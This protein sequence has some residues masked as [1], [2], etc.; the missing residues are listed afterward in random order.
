M[1]DK[2]KMSWY[3]RAKDF[4]ERNVVNSKIRYLQELRNTLN[5]I[6]DLVFQ[7]GSLAKQDNVNIITSKKI[8]SYPTVHDLLLE[9]DAIALDNPW[10][11][12]DLCLAANEI[13][14]NLIA[15]LKVE[16]KE[17]SYGKEKETYVRK[18]WV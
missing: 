4:S 9:A 7:S 6:S 11:F 8:S 18:G 2:N 10:R 5:K 17:L 3:K 12:R 13:I 1:G 14:D 15:E 16:R